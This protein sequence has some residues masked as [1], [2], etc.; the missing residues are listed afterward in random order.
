MEVDKKSKSYQ[1]RRVSPPARNTAQSKWNSFPNRNI[2]F[3]DWPPRAARID[4]WTINLYAHQNG[5]NFTVTKD[6]LKA[7]LGIN[8]VM[9]R[10]KLPRIAEYWRVDDVIS[11]DS[12]QNTMIWNCFCEILKNLQFADNR[13]GDKID[14]VFKMIPVIDHLNSKFSEV[15]SNDREQSIDEHMGKFNGRSGMKQYIKAFRVNLVICI[16]WIST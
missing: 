7:F 5:R 12:I 6:E 13:K 1:A 14:K 4:S 3:G 16:R 2:F 8:F 9:A 10:N 15:L 11:N